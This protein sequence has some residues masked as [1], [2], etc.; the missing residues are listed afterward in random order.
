MK[1][2]TKSSDHYLRLSLLVIVAI[3]YV[4]ILAAAS[5]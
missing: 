5:L 3:S 1:P 2:S 4:G